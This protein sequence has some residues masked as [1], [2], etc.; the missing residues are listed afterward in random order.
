[1]SDELIRK[2][3]KLIEK[4]IP[5][6]SPPPRNA[7]PDKKVGVIPQEPPRRPPSNRKGK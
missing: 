2:I 4:A 6:Q 7:G 1:M 5:Q 3:D